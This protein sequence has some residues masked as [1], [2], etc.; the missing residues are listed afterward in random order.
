M[1]EEKIKLRFFEKNNLDPSSRER[2]V[3]DTN[4]S[5]STDI[6]KVNTE[7]EDFFLSSKSYNKSIFEKFVAVEYLDF[8]TGG[9]EETGAIR[10]VEITTGEPEIRYSVNNSISSRGISASF[11]VIVNKNKEAILSERYISEDT[12]STGSGSTAV[13][14]PPPP[15]SVA[16][17]GEMRFNPYIQFSVNNVETQFL[18][19]YEEVGSD[20]NEIKGSNSIPIDKFNGF[21]DFLKGNKDVFTSENVFSFNE[22]TSLEPLGSAST[23]ENLI[24]RVGG[25]QTPQRDIQT[26]ERTTTQIPAGRGWTPAPE[27][28]SLNLPIRFPFVSDTLTARVNYDF[29]YEVWSRDKVYPLSMFNRATQLVYPLE[30]DFEVRNVKIEKRGQSVENLTNSFL[31]SPTRITETTPVGLANVVITS[32]SPVGGIGGGFN[33][34]YVAYIPVANFNINSAWDR[35][36]YLNFL[37]S[38][39]PIGRYSIARGNNLDSVEIGFFNSYQG[40]SGGGF[41]IESRTTSSTSSGSTQDEV[42]QNLL[43]SFNSVTSGN[44]SDE[45]FNQALEFV[46]ENFFREKL[47]EVNVEDTNLLGQ[48][49]ASL[50]FSGVNNQGNGLIPYVSDFGVNNPTI[51]SSTNVFIEEGIIK[52]RHFGYYTKQTISNFLDRQIPRINPRDRSSLIRRINDQV[53]ERWH[54]PPNAGQGFTTRFFNI[55]DER[56]TYGDL[57]SLPSNASKERIRNFLRRP[58][59]NVSILLQSSIDA[60]NEA[61]IEAN[62][63][64][65]GTNQTIIERIS[66]REIRPEELIES[67]DGDF[68]FVSIN[69][70]RIDPDDQGNPQ[71]LVLV[72]SRGSDKAPPPHK[73]F[74]DGMQIRTTD[75]KRLYNF[76]FGSST[77]KVHEKGIDGNPF[78]NIRNSEWRWDISNISSPENFDDI[79]IFKLIFNK[80]G[81]SGGGSIR[82]DILV[83]KSTIET[84]R[85]KEFPS[86]INGFK[87]LDFDFSTT[88][89]SLVLEGKVEATDFSAVRV[90]DK[91]GETP[92]TRDLKPADAT[93]TESIGKTTLEWANLPEFSSL[94]VNKGYNLSIIK[95]AVESD[96]R[97]FFPRPLKEGT[98]AP[99]I[100]KDG[101]D[102]KVRFK[103]LTDGFPTDFLSGLGLTNEDKST[104][105]DFFDINETNKEED[106]S[107]TLPKALENK[108]LTAGDKFLFN[109]NLDQFNPFEISFTKTT[110]FYFD[111]IVLLNT[112]LKDIHVFDSSNNELIHPSD[113]DFV[114]EVREEGL[115]H[116]VLFLKNPI[117]SSSIKLVSYITDKDEVE[118]KVGKVYLLK[119]IGE[120]SQYP[121]I[122]PAIDKGRSLSKDLFNKSFI[123]TQG[124]S[125]DYTLEFDPLTEE[126]D[127]DLAGNLF[128]READVNEFI[129]WTCGGVPI[130]QRVKNT[131]G[132]RFVDLVKSLCS[133]EFNLAYEGGMITSSGVRFV[134]ETTEV[135]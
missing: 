117:T 22:I 114:K 11:E 90:L 115:R 21:F 16:D 51:E 2:F 45:P 56:L 134:I 86:F 93:I 67:K 104:F 83:Q 18:G 23:Y 14:F 64:R 1:S 72:M 26:T 63:N 13:R 88:S 123:T 135:R 57:L 33:F 80:S 49:P 108:T 112:N 9:T 85:E 111:T 37:V 42:R 6:L 27:A 52:R 58:A 12:S 62:R 116:V 102:L 77:F 60:R 5:N 130:K 118:K 103:G 3:V 126:E 125:I 47:E 7:Y 25:F 128:N 87:I 122:K 92:I 36:E 89:F 65:T 78:P 29:S 19:G 31:T 46:F 99:S 8:F 54:V 61:A 110:D 48:I 75:N 105:T 39:M 91:D 73:S 100:E 41:L 4:D 66:Q 70:L 55:E 59:R 120:F 44:R 24:K 76:S 132:F 94:K 34:S 28:V 119:S 127:L 82:R 38:R 74:F 95:G 106:G 20:I 129:V 50:P 30:R 43:N 84:I 10:K 101:D 17:I 69:A 40:V 71:D 121:V 109:L 131:K 98:P 32:F 133:N 113:I 35:A 107:F 79:D 53:G 96:S 124:E 68:P 81:S 15:L 97:F